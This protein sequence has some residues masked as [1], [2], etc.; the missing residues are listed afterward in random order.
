ME[1]RQLIAFL[2]V[3]AVATCAPRQSRAQEGEQ[4][5]ARPT[6]PEIAPRDLEIRG[7]VNPTLPSLQRQPITSFD[8]PEA[9]F[10]VPA[11]RRP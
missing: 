10:Q 1:S 8:V 2:L 4:D 11:S 3:L 5:P 9:M 6:L 7:R